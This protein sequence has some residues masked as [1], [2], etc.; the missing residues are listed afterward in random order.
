[1]R[2]SVLLRSEMFLLSTHQNVGRRCFP[3]KRA[4][5]FLFEQT[6]L[7]FSLSQ[8]TDVAL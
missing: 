8:H 4:R 6:V 5:A 1:M 7:R 3:P 2:E